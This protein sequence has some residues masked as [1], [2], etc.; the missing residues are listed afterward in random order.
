MEKTLR[1]QRNGL[2]RGGVRLVAIGELHRLPA[3][4]R[5]LLQ[6]MQDETF[7]HTPSMAAEADGNGCHTES[8]PSRN[9]YGDNDSDSGRIHRR[10][11]DTV[12]A[13]ANVSSATNLGAAAVAPGAEYVSSHHQNG[14][15]QAGRYGVAGVPI[16]AHSVQNSTASRVSKGPA[17]SERQGIRDEVAP[18]HASSRS[19]PSATSRIPPPTMTLCLAISYGGRAE[20]AAAARELATEAAAGRLDP[21]D[22]NEETLSRCLRTVRLGIPD[23]DLVVRTSG[24]NR[25]SNLLLW[26][27][28]YTEL[29]VVGKAWPDFRRP[30]LVEAFRHVCACVRR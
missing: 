29:Y 6:E 5:C 17:S 20:I 23:P 10:V 24:E 16:D 1:E 26:Q 21:A 2:R 9:G 28:A 12:T 22:V 13:L 15:S 3:R 4:L 18:P 8:K 27:A 11:S 25:L 7:R 14:S 19:R 30:D